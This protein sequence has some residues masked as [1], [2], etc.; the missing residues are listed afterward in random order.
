M[1]INPTVSRGSATTQIAPP[2]VAAVVV[3][4]PGAWFAETLQALAQQDYPNLQTLFFVTSGS[5]T[6]EEIRKQL[7][8]AIIRTVDGNPGYGPLMNE[9]GRLVEG[10]GGFFCL[11]HDDVALEPDA[12][13]RLM[14]EMFRSN[15]GIV[16][17]KLVMWDDPTIVQSVGFGVDRIG[18][19]SS[20]ADVGEKDQEQHDAVRDVE[21][22]GVAVDVGAV[23]GAGVDAF[24]N[25]PAGMLGGGVVPACCFGVREDPGERVVDGGADER[26]PCDTTAGLVQRLGA[27]QLVAEAAGAGVPDLG[28]AEHR[29]EGAGLVEDRVADDGEHVGRGGVEVDFAAG[30]QLEVR[31]LV[32]GVAAGQACHA[33]LPRSP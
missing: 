19:V 7:P 22:V 16:G 30:M 3:H 25:E 12:V 23:R 20:I 6:A 1:A 4:E 29:L 32:D 31:D 15:A 9:I 14:E 24:F 17:P 33:S 2:V 13:S 28:G 21:E 11:L 8:D 27:V 5:Q 18:E 10:D 26:L